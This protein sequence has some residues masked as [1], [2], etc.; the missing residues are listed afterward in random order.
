MLNE[1]KRGGRI[2]SLMD[3]SKFSVH[4]DDIRTS[5]AWVPTA[6]IKVEKVNNNSIYNYKL[7]NEEVGVS[8]F[9]MKKN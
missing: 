8:V 3:S 5:C 1:I 9:A 2:L 4:S 6:E 7:T